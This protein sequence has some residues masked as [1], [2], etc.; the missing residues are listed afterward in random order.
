[1]ARVNSGGSS[2]ALRLTPLVLGVCGLIFCTAAGALAGKFAPWHFAMGALSL[3]SI[4]G[5]LLWV[6][7]VRWRETLSSFVYTLFFILCLGM[8]Y[9]ISANRKAHYDITRDQLHTL[10]AQ[11]TSLLLRVKPQETLLLQ[12]FA[13]NKDHQ[14]LIRFLQTYAQVTPRF[15]FEVYDPERDLDI[16]QKLG[17]RVT[18][19][20][21][22][23][24]LQ[25]AAGAT[26]RR[27]D[28]RLTV[29]DQLRENTLTNAIARVVQESQQVIYWSS[30][31]GEKRTDKSDTSLTKVAQQLSEASLP[32][33]PLRLQEGRIPD[34]A[35]ALIIA[36]PKIDLSDFD[37]DLLINYLDEGGKLF[38]L[39][40][41]VINS[42]TGLKNFGTVL[43]HLGLESPN[44]FVVDPIAVNSSKLSYT[45]Q[46]MW[47]KHAIAEGTHRT[48]FILN[49]ARPVLSNGMIDKS[50]RLEAI[51]VSNEQC[52][53][54]PA[55]K[56]RSVRRLSPPADSADIQQQV[57]AVSAAKD[58]PTGRYG[59][60]MRAVIVG[61]SDAFSDA[62]V[63]N[64][65]DAGL[66]FVQSVNWLRERPDLLQVPP[67]FLTST[68]INITETTKYMLMGIY[69]LMGLVIVAGGTTWTIIRRRSR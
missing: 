55:D 28:G 13:P 37:R 32:V 30:G 47:T 51:F 33:T 39:L 22:V 4:T 62:I 25:D 29:G 36:G 49:Q 54:E 69:L 67:R 65:G 15:Q 26:I 45:P 38:L 66:F 35:A 24:T 56:L 60:S 59:K 34:D 52:W 21:M 58:V 44:E 53:A 40:D 31:N 48:P 23:V 41:P 11:S 6:Q 64:N 1:M 18:T 9:L 3:V 17:G 68:P 27:T 57:L 12:V 19:G 42:G 20:A 10:S 8:L 43:K 2:T 7:D 50:M 14:A 61:D 16:V 46:I 5:S 63:E